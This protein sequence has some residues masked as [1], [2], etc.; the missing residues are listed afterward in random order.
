VAAAIGV[1]Q[2]QISRIEK[3]VLSALRNMME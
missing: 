3:K 2:V 1:S